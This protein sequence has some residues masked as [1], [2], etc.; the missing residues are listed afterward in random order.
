MPLNATRLANALQPDIADAFTAIGAVSGTAL[1]TL[2]TQLA[3]AIAS[4]VVDEIKNN[5][6]VT[7]TTASA[8]TAGGATGTGSGT[9]A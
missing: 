4:K 3:S 1:T 2:S 5:A 6:A 7:V 8:C 9:V